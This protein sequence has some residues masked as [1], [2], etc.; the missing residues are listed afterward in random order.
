MR[1]RDLTPVQRGELAVPHI[2]QAGP[3]DARARVEDRL[4][5]AQPIERGEPVGL[6]HDRR[7]ATAGVGPPLENTHRAP[8]PAKL[9]RKTQAGETGADDRHVHRL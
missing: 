1:V 6:E 3:V 2:P 8:L 4:E 7:S 5:N 9:A